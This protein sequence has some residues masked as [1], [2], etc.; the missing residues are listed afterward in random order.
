MSVDQK[1]FDPPPPP[2][3]WLRWLRRIPLL[4]RLFRKRVKFKKLA[5]PIFKV[6][7][8]KSELLAYRQ[9]IRKIIENNSVKDVR[10][11]DKPWHRGGPR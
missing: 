8:T 4:G 9:P 1:F 3:W 10:C 11:A 2:P 6:P 5:V 7:K